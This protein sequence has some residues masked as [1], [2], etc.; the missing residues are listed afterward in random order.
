MLEQPR[1]G[2]QHGRTEQVIVN[3]EIQ[4]NDHERLKLNNDCEANKD[5][6]L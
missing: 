6:G 2:F 1:A 5:G 4:P 3:D